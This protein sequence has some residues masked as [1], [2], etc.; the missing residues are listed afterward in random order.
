MSTVLVTGGSGFIGSH[1]ILQ[2]LAAGHQ[3]RATIRDLARAPQVR[4]QLRAP[5]GG[6][7]PGDRLTLVA[8]D[9]TRDAGWADAVAGCE[10]V[11][12]VA[13]PFPESVPRHE[14]ELIVPAR[15]GTLRVLRAAR[16][17][18]VRRV[19]LTSSFAAVGYGRGAH[20]APFDET[21][22]TDPSGD[23]RTSRPSS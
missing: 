1:C 10:Y 2:L 21:S 3:V 16:D 14:D 15:D 22:W 13:S 5:E 6:A 19:V 9:L 18:G 8:A 23:V 20:P 11:L 7:D 4:A 12:H 17:A